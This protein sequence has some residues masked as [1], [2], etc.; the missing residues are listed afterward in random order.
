M[1]RNRRL[2]SA[3]FAVGT[4]LAW[5]GAA[6][7]QVDVATVG[8]PAPDFTLPDEDGN[9]HSLSDL[10][11]QIVVLEWTSST[12][13]YVQRHYN[14]GN[15]QQTAAA[16]S[17]QGVV[18][19]AIDSTHYNTPADTQAWKATQGFAYPTLQDP[20]GTVG[21]LYGARTT[22]HMYVID[23]AGILRYEGAIDDNPRG[24]LENPTNYVRQAVQALLS[25]E[26][27]PVTSTDPYGCT[28]KY[29]EE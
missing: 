1:T 2:L 16:L 24:R 5:A 25:G 18:W 27:V 13:P 6:S 9:S 28:V 10:A 23:A 19:L 29:P 22:P 4:V 14:S 12:C 26:E 15:M 8:Q 20:E 3:L 17:E 11:G 7:A 21:Y